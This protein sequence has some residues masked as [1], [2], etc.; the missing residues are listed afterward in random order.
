MPSGRI[1]IGGRRI[2]STDAFLMKLLACMTTQRIVHLEIA[3][4]IECTGDS[5][6]WEDEEKKE[7]HGPGISHWVHFT[8]LVGLGVV[9]SLMRERAD[10]LTRQPGLWDWYEIPV[11]PANLAHCVKFLTD[12]VMTGAP[13]N[14]LS[15]TYPCRLMCRTHYPSRGMLKQV[16]PAVSTTRPPLNVDQKQWNCVELV[17]AALVAAG[18]FELGSDLPP[19]NS[20]TAADLLEALH[21]LYMH[22]DCPMFRSVQR[23]EF[24]EEPVASN[25][26]TLL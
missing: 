9:E 26:F 10:N 19:I 5:C 23:T 15:W 7:P 14:P 16:A 22:K 24:S 3:V 4:P 6:P 11:P 1:R 12:Q 18:V 25:P 20:C 17:Y 21:A 13:Y 8:S 2:L